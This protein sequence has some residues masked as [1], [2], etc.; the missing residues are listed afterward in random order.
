M[1][2]NQNNNQQDFN[3]KLFYKELGQLLYAVAY[4][5]GKVRKQEVDA[6]HEFILKELLPLEHTVDSS[7]MNQAFY[8]QFEFSEFAEKCTPPQLV[9]M[10]YLSYL[11]SNAKHLTDKHK[12]SI[13]NAVKKVA[14]AYKHINKKEQELVDS[15]KMELDKL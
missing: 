1:T 4:A 7:G 8:T 15:L 13:I 2:L 11:K 10:N 6:L 3:L 9:Y 5:D 14:D 12:A